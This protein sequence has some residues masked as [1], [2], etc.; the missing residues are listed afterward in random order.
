[1]SGRLGGS[2]ADSNMT[3]WFGD[4]LELD[5][6]AYELRSSGEPLKLSR[7][8]MDV[9]RLLIERQGLLVS[10]EQIVEKIWGHGGVSVNTDRNINETVRRIRRV[11]NDNA[12]Q[13]RF[14]QTVYKKGYR[15]IA[16]VAR[17]CAAPV[18]QSRDGCTGTELQPADLEVILPDAT[19]TTA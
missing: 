17:V 16:P 12:G 11:L 15:F 8:P 14:V 9:L 13:P 19:A 3:F 7:I 4:G 2:R 18:R 6:G 1:M 10:R 5:V